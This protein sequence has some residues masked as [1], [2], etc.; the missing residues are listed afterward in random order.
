VGVEETR[1]RAAESDSWSAEGVTPSEQWATLPRTGTRVRIQVVGDGPNV[2]FVHG[3]SVNGTCFAP[4][5]SRLHHMRCL[6]I[7]RPGCGLSEPLAHPVADV[8]AFESFADTLIVDVLDAL[9]LDRAHVVATSLGGHFAF[10]A[11]AAHPDRIDRLLELGFPIGAPSGPMPLMMRIVGIKPLAR[12]MTRMP[13]GPRIARTMIRGLGVR[14]E[15]ITNEGTEWFRAVLNHTDT[16]R[17]E[18]DGPPVL[19][20]LR[21]VDEAMLFSDDLLGRIRAPVHFVWGADDPFGGTD[22]AERF[23][24]RVPGATLEL[25]P[26]SGHVV[27]LDEPDLV[28]AAAQRFLLGTP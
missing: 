21:G 9:E 27:W 10:R 5:V 15:A 11:A 26:R 28:A 20:G 25:V 22:V 17:N 24:P 4:L 3:G 6:V 23:V 14:D 2:L 12:V 19:R 1:F 16:M 8:P 18:I 13:V 7:D